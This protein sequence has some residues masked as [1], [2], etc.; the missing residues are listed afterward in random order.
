VVDSHAPGHSRGDVAVD[1]RV[2]E[3][4]PGIPLTF[5]EW[6]NA[7]TNCPEAV[8][9]DLLENLEQ[10]ESGDLEFSLDDPIPIFIK[11]ECYDEVKDP[12]FIVSLPTMMKWKH[13]VL[14]SAVEKLVYGSEHCVKT[15][16][17]DERP[18]VLV[19][20]L[21]GARYYV[22]SD[23]S[24]FESTITADIRE[25]VHEFVYKKLLPGWERDID[26][27]FEELVYTTKYKNRYVSFKYS[28]DNNNMPGIREV[29][30]GVATAPRKSGEQQTALENWLINVLLI[31]FCAEESKAA[32][33][34]KCEGDDG[35][36]AVDEGRFTFEAGRK[37]GFNIKEQKYESL[38]TASFCGLVFDPETLRNQ[39]DPFKTLL[40]FKHIPARYVRSNR[41]HILS[42][43][44]AKA[45]SYLHSYPGCPI[46]TPFF[47]EVL[48]SV[49]TSADWGIDRRVKAGANPFT[50]VDFS[51]DI[52]TEI[53]DSSRIFMQDNFGISV[54][55][56]LALESCLVKYLRVSW[57]DIADLMP[58]VWETGEMS[59]FLDGLLYYG[60]DAPSDPLGFDFAPL[61]A[62]PV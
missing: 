12:R 50:H 4:L 8:R 40:K 31:R 17:V 5:R 54:E 62:E 44:K 23:F 36:I 39:T 33:R 37:L 20:D 45:L 13:G 30:E 18:Q 3:A 29:L 1:E 6:I 49:K 51:K 53:A 56:Q 15:G 7:K 21:S 60:P 16:S 25:I 26:E 43:Y 34:F 35:L 11:D 57:D 48:K 19:R 42:L 22:G 10:F 61:P 24:S 27:M 55:T 38:N 32:I 2:E 41:A 59:E 14:I 9:K 52:V 46:L 58:P 47:L 28:A